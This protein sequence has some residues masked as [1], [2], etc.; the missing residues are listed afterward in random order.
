MKFMN[1]RKNEIKLR[2]SDEE[3]AELNRYVRMTGMSREQYIRTVLKGMRP[4]QT[5]PLDYYNMVREIRRVGYN[6]RQVAQ[7]AYTQNFVDAPL[8]NENAQRVLNA[9]DD[10]MMI[11][12]PRGEAG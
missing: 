12:L 9:C 5:P 7:R 4:V 6:M 1:Y 3:L 8:Y 2:L 10:L 11:C